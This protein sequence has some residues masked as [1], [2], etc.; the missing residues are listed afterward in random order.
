M[1]SCRLL[2]EH[3]RRV[4]HPERRHLEG[5]L[6]E[7]QLH[8]L[9]VRRPVDRLWG[10]HLE[11]LRQ[12]RHHLEDHHPVDRLRGLHHLEGHHLGLRL[13]EGHHWGD[14]HLEGLRRELELVLQKG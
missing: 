11:V 9:G 7:L 5:R 3:L 4:L 8:H 2:G 14:R 10:L 12:E 1:N 13:P 6:L